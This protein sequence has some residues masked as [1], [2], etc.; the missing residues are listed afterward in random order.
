MQRENQS[1]LHLQLSSDGKKLVAYSK[2]GLSTGRVSAADVKRHHLIRSSAKGGGNTSTVNALMATV[3]VGIVGMTRGIIH[4]V[5]FTKTAGFCA[6]GQHD[7]RGRRK[8]SHRWKA[9]PLQRPV[10]WSGGQLI[11]GRLDLLF[12]GSQRQLTVPKNGA[13]AG[14]FHPHHLS[15]VRRASF[16]G[17]LPRQ[18]VASATSAAVG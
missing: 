1:R 12:G 14:G 15:Q 9:G 6:C 4:A 10:C 13:F 16:V 2:A 3:P 7:L 11:G 5:P 18:R 17:P 8:V